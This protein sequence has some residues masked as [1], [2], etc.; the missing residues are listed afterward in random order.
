MG[1][2]NRMNG[3]VGEFKSSFLSCEKDVEAIIKKLFV[4]SRPHSDMLKRLML[5]NTPDCL[6]DMTNQAY[7][8]K[9]RDTSVKEMRDKGYIL[10]EPKIK[11]KE[12]EE[13]KSHIIITFTN[14]TP[15]KTNPE[16]RDCIIMIDVLCHTDYWDIGNYRTRPMKI[17]GYIDG[18]LNN[19]RLS[20]IGQLKFLGC[21]EL[22]MNEQLSGY[23]LMYSAV[24]GSDDFIPGKKD[25]RPEDMVPVE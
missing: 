12:N 17:V 14:F 4:D 3:Y 18:L 8:D 15:N 13:V 21:N 25:L 6:Y 11:Q 7:I 20:G 22:T 24:H 1:R 9:I 16:F 2:A 19:T 23:C 10:L 5:I